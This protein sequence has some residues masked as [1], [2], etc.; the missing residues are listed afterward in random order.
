MLARPYC[1]KQALSVRV[2]IMNI[3]KRS[4]FLLRVVMCCILSVVAF[5]S[6]SISRD[7]S[8]GFMEEEVL[9][10]TQRIKLPT[11]VPF[12]VAYL[13]NHAK[14]LVIVACHGVA[15]AED[16]TDVELLDDVWYLLDY[17]KKSNF[18]A[19]FVRHIQKGI[20]LAREHGDSLLLFSGGETRNDVGPRSEATSYFQ[21]ADHFNFFEQP[22]MLRGERAHPPVR[23]RTSTEE[24]ARDSFDNLL[25]SICRFR[26]LVGRYPSEIYL[27]GFSYK[28]TRFIDLHRAAIRFPLPRFHYI[29]VDPSS[30]QESRGSRLRGAHFDLERLQHFEETMSIEPFKTDPY[31]CF[32]DILKQKRAQRNPFRRTIPYEL[33][34]PELKPLL[35]WCGPDYFNG[36]LPW[37]T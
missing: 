14:K 16:L 25:F 24:Y 21:V 3:R 5:I 10:V 27:V 23:G 13:E 12:D 33:S 31:G 29:G 19:A 26:E 1:P 9:R 32:S 11:F 30:E 37:L 22:V 28:K 6:I 18:P 35:T 20:E 8:F 4:D 15:I 2:N 36:S 34:C 7:H 17:Q